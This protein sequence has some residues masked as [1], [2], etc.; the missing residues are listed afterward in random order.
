MDANYD[1][2]K[3]NKGKEVDVNVYYLIYYIYCNPSYQ[4]G[5]GKSIIQRILQ[6]QRR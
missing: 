1:K 2:I 5:N 6:T 4:G 3:L